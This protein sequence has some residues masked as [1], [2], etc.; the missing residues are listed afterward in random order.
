LSLSNVDHPDVDAMIADLDDLLTALYVLA[1]DLLP[2]RPKSL[3]GRKPKITDAEVIC[4]AVPSRFLTARRSGASC[5]WRAGG[6]GTCSAISPTSPASTSA[7]GPWGRRSRRSSVT[8]LEAR[9]RGVTGCGSSTP[10]R[11]PC[12][13][14][15]ETVKRSRFAGYAAY[16]WCAAHSRHFWGF[17][18]YLLCASD[19]M[20]ICF[21]LAPANAPEREVAAAMLR[22][23]EFSGYTVI[24]DKGL[25]GAEIEQL[26]AALGGLFM[27]PD[28]RDE[29]PRFGSLGG[30]RQWIEAI[31]DQ[32]KDQPRWSATAPTR[33]LGFARASPSDCSPSALPSGT[34]GAFGRAGELEGPIRSLVAYDH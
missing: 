30:V 6:S 28:H 26:V 8:W 16:G 2:K 7:S 25:S 29:G 13:A 5:A 18:L 27:R 17:K 3:P 23:V 22:R 1:D 20:P 15:R 4:L 32:L 33:S 19:G 9:H 31:F 11:C 24:G 10:P 14:S 34:T 21:E 12:G